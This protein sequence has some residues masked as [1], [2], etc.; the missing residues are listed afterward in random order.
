M[1]GALQ[2]FVESL[3]KLN[4]CLLIY[5]LLQLIKI[6]FYSLKTHTVWRTDRL[7]GALQRIGKP[8]RDL[9]CPQV[10]Q[11]MDELQM[12]DLRNVH[13]VSVFGQMLHMPLP[14]VGGD[15]LKRYK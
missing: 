2:I 1:V 14:L 5:V 7:S 10:I 12:D 13:E 9:V 11:K 6:H 15:Y 8:A 3:D 4:I